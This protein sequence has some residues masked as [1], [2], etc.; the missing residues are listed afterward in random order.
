MRCVHSVPNMFLFL[1]C[2]LIMCANDRAHYGLMVVFRLHHH[3]TDESEFIELNINVRYI[4]PSVCLKLN[5]SPRLSSM[6]YMG[7]LVFSLPISH[8]ITLTYYHH[9]IGSITHLQ[10]FRVSSW[11]NVVRCMSVYILMENSLYAKNQL[12]GCPAHHKY[13][14]V[15]IRSHWRW[16]YRMKPTAV[17]FISFTTV[18]QGDTLHGPFLLTSWIN[19]IPGSWHG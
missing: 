10:L 14:V 5:Q 12:C 19:L 18:N 4:L 16:P 6:Q 8:M 7:L 17:D 2:S 1:L 13:R 15:S 3:Y 11:K 9:Q